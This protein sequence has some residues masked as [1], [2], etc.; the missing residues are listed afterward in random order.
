MV[1]QRLL[2]W[3][4]EEKKISLIPIGVDTNLFNLSNNNYKS[5][6]RS[7]LGFKKGEFVIGSFQ[8]DGIG[9]SKGLEPKLIKG[10]D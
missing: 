1:Y 10:P 3:G 2:N 9:W 4:V 8:K 6:I 5:E 7:K